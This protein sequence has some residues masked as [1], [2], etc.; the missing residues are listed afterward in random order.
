MDP[1]TA[2]VESRRGRDDPPLPTIDAAQ[3]V[4]NDKQRRGHQSDQRNETSR[5]MYSA[6]TGDFTP[7]GMRGSHPGDDRTDLVSVTVLPHG[8]TDLSGY[9]QIH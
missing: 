5:V 2:A 3:R 9:I 4:G 7:P 6:P 1:P 8:E